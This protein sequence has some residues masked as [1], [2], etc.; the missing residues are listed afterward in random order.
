MVRK[1]WWAHQQEQRYLVGRVPSGGRGR[2]S[3]FE[4]LRTPGPVW[5]SLEQPPSSGDADLWSL[6]CVPGL[7]ASHMKADIQASE[8]EPSQRSLD[9]EG[10][11]AGGHTPARN[12]ISVRTDAWSLRQAS[13]AP[14]AP[15]LAALP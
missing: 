14:R 6:C 3:P 4:G 7:L 11:G 9:F 13:A 1:G 8:M 2:R 12:P 5:L 10:L 15:A